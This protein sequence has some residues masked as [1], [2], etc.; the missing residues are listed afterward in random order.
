MT[1]NQLISHD[2]MTPHFTKMTRILIAIVLLLFNFLSEVSAQTQ[3]LTSHDSAMVLKYL[4][5]YEHELNEEKNI[6]EASRYLNETAL[7]YWEH[8]QYKNAIKYYEMSLDLNMRIQNENGVAMLHN[9]L[10]MLHSDVGN[11]E[12]AFDYFNKTLAARRANKEKNQ[13][14]QALINISTA[15]NNI[16]RYDE[17]AKNLEEALALARELNNMEQMRSCYGQLSETYEKAGNSE[18]SLFYFNLYR[19]FHD[20]IQRQ[21]VSFLKSELKE[22]QL[23]N[24]IERQKSKSREDELREKQTQLQRIRSENQ[25]FDEKL[26]EADSLTS[27]VYASLNKKELELELRKKESELTALQLREKTAL[28]ESVKDKATMT[29]TFSILIIISLSALLIFII[30]SYRKTTKQAKELLESHEELRRTQE[31]LIKS[32]KMA[33]VGVL[34][35]GIA[36]EINNPL[37]FIKNGAKALSNHVNKQMNGKAES[38]QPFMDIIN[39]GINRCTKIISGLS[40]VSRTGDDMNEACDVHVIVD[41]CLVILGSRILNKVKVEKHYFNGELIVR[42]NEGKLHQAVMNIIANALQAMDEGG[43]LTITTRMVDR[44]AVIEIQDTGTGI[45]QENLRKLGDPF[46][47]TKPPGK[48]TGLGLYIT[49]SIIADHQGTIEVQSVPNELTEFEIQLPI[50]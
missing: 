7:L 35:A 21:E 1:N 33:A 37:N 50:K 46:F 27:Q 45:T 3:P 25:F 42:G 13:M 9:N 20:L 5:I 15:L 40:H 38:V 14:I 10:G 28:A 31:H 23:V 19:T 43:V 4:K 41:N 34:T 48:G 26:K 22:E 12:K 32:E 30:L 39:E 17:S 2:F 6:K 47:T 44:M 36:H 24:E 49:Y 18:R 29:R 8:N 11:Y 16:G